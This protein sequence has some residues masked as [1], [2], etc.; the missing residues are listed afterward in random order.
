VLKLKLLSYIFYVLKCFLR[1]NR[2]VGISRSSFDLAQGPSRLPIFQPGFGGDLSKVEVAMSSAGQSHYK[3]KTKDPL[4]LDYFF[5]FNFQC[6]KPYRCYF[7][8][9]LEHL[10]HLLTFVFYIISVNNDF[11]VQN[12]QCGLTLNEAEWDEEWRCVLR[13]A[14]PEPRSSSAMSS[15]ASS[16]G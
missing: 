9:D 1:P 15:S 6:R 3:V 7:G 11:F 2:H 16:N 13:L 8:I 5:N 4:Q 12:S 14:S 10:E